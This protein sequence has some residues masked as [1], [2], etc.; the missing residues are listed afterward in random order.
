MGKTFPNSLQSVFVDGISRCIGLVV[1]V[2]T[3]GTAHSSSLVLG[4]HR[5]TVNVYPYCRT[6]LSPDGR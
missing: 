3:Y 4:H 5:T 6:L 1:V 2:V